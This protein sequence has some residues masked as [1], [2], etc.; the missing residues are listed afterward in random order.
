[1]E[2]YLNDYQRREAIGPH[3]PDGHMGKYCAPCS[4]TNGATT[5]PCAGALK[6]RQAQRRAHE[7]G[8]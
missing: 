8:R 7:G 2:S 1:M 3:C 4:A 6:L 5:W